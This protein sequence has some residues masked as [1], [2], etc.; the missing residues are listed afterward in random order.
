MRHAEAVIGSGRRG[1]GEEGIKQARGLRSVAAGR[2]ESRG[3]IENTMTGCDL[4]NRW[5]D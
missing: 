1:G 4:S 5:I 2:S 3:G